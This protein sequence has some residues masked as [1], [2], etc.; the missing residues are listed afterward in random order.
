M[1]VMGEARERYRWEPVAVA[2]QFERMPLAHGHRDAFM[3]R[4][5]RLS[6]A[7]IRCERWP[8]GSTPAR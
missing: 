7:E 8:D 3:R 4:E 6:W 2:Q 1:V 5:R